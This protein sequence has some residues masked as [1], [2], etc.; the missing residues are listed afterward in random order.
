V[1]GPDGAPVPPVE[2]KKRERRKK[3][4]EYS[5][6]PLPAHV[7]AQL[8]AFYKFSAD[9]DPSL[10][11]G[12][13]EAFSKVYYVSPPIA[14]ILR[15]AR[16]DRVKV[17][18]TGQRVFELRNET[19]TQGTIECPYRVCQEG[20][21]V[22][23]QYAQAQVAPAN[24]ADITSLVRDSCLKHTQ[25]SEAAQRA[26]EQAKNGCVVFVLKAPNNISEREVMLATWKTNYTVNLMI[27]KIDQKSLL[28]KLGLSRSAEN[29]DSHSD[30][31]EAAK[32]GG[33]DDNN[34]DAP[35][36]EGSEEDEAML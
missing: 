26:L 21:N 33:D 2:K 20:I 9:L 34:V 10:L 35:E 30:L 27:S 18:H 19:K 17:V 8:Q 23:A 29:A 25:F 32:A 24:E 1:L 11:F 3:V 12:R 28:N 14:A 15:V 16:N 6:F 5:Y 31:D 36:A 4:E 13:S 22:I 7:F